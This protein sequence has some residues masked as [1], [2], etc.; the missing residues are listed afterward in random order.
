MLGAIIPMSVWVDSQHVGTLT[1]GKSLSLTVSPGR[2]RVECAMQHDRALDAPGQEFDVPAGR[3]LVVLVAPGRLTG[4]P[5][6]TAE[7]D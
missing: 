2:H 6:F 5:T 3:K 4:R 1:S 7:L